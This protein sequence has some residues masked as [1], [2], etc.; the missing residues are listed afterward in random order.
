MSEC[1]QGKTQDDEK[2]DDD[3]I[4]LYLLLDTTI[5]VSIIQLYMCP[6]TTVPS[7]YYIECGH[8]EMQHDEGQDDKARKGG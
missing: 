4:L 2:Q 6:H 1:G 3:A 7:Y 8:G 5:Y